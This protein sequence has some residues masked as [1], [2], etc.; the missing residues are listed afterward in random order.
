MIKTILRAVLVGS[1]IAGAAHAST[2]IDSTGGPSG[3]FATPFGSPDT[4]TYGQTFVTGA[5]DTV[6]DSFTM[7]LSGSAALNLRGYVGAWNGSTMTSLLYTSATVAGPTGTNSPVTF[8]PH[9]QL[10][11]NT[12]YVAFLSIS[13]L[14][15]QPAAA[16]AMNVVSDTINGGFVF[17]NNGTNFIQLTGG[18]WGNLAPADIWFRA[19]LSAPAAVPEPG[20]LALIGLALLGGVAVRR[21]KT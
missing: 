10:L 19:S 4:S 3:G 6:L 2:L 20:S 15:A 11:A 8:A 16:Y 5:T 21:R 9:L 1:L 7:F 18:S 12:P 14:A 17:S 13:Q